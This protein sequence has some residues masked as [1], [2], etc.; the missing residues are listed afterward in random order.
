[1]GLPAHKLRESIT[2]WPVTGTDDYGG[3][4]YGTPICVD[5]RYEQKQ[6]LF[7]TVD[8]E[9]VTSM[10]IAYIDADVNPGDYVAQGDQTTQADPTLATDAHRVRNYSKVSDLRNLNVIR[11]VWL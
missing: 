2:I 7:L 1:M 9:E 8:A 3:F 6:E 10:A 5:G 11:K 4:T